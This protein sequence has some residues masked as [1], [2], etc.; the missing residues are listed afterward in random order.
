MLRFNDEINDYNN[1]KSKQNL[2]IIIQ[3]L[4]YKD[5]EMAH[6]QYSFK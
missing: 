5:K 2:D 3:K 6:I 1:Q 4:I